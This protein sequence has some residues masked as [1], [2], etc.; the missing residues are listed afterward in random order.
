MDVRSGWEKVPTSSGEFGAKNA[1]EEVRPEH[2]GDGDL[3]D[4]IRAVEVAATVGH[5]MGDVTEIM[6]WRE[7]EETYGLVTEMLPQPGKW[8]DKAPN[9]PVVR[10]YPNVYT[11][12][13]RP[14]GMSED[15]HER[16]RLSATA[17]I[18]KGGR[19]TVED[20]AKIWVRDIDPTKFGI[21]LGG[22]D[23]IIYYSAKAGVPRGRSA[24]SPTSPAPGA[25]PP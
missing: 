6:D 13:D 24:S 23:Q 15:G 8:K 5:S 3:F 2:R 14:P 1:D 16:H 20:V 18:E 19:V 10:G 12:H 11:V 17:V 9:L 4:R 22:Q 7:I 25:S 21:L